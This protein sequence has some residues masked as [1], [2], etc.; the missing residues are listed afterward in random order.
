MQRL[1]HSLQIAMIVILISACASPTMLGSADLVTASPISSAQV[2]HEVDA[3][4][5]PP[6]PGL[7]D[8]NCGFNGANGIEQEMLAR[9]NA[10][11]AEAR[12]CGDVR[13]ASASP[14]VWNIKLMNASYR[15]SIDMARSNLVSHTSLDSREL[16]NRIIEAGY[17]FERAGENIAAGQ[18]SVA[19]VVAAWEKSPP[20]C[21]TLMAPELQDVGV[22]CVHK[23]VSFYKYY[24][25]MDLARPFDKTPELVDESNI[26]RRNRREELPKDWK[27]AIVR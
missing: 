8:P 3:R 19:N 16:R 2:A 18:N 7:S 4:T 22:A 14:L 15:H 24:W 23:K 10:L 5:L 1:I 26:K 6:E 17:L 11:R 27:E 25:T 9:I 13:F 12:M 21:S 20:H